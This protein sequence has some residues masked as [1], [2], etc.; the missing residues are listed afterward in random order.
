MRQDN[1]LLIQK[2]QKW[3]DKPSKLAYN[4][5]EPKRR[6]FSLGQSPL[7]DRIFKQKVTTF[8]TFFLYFSQCLNN[9]GY[10]WNYILLVGLME[11]PWN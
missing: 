7:V 11:N 1:P 9:L 8:K 3:I 6:D 5:S 10:F 2:I 4:L